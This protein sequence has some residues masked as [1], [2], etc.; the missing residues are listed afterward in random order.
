M[1]LLSNNLDQSCN[2]T[3]TLNDISHPD[4]SPFAEI[5]EDDYKEIMNIY[6]LQERDQNQNNSKTSNSK[7]DQRLQHLDE[8]FKRNKHL[9]INQ[10]SVYFSKGDSWTF[11]TDTFTSGLSSN[12]Q[13][14]QLVSKLHALGGQYKKL[15]KHTSTQNVAE[16]TSVESSEGYLPHIKE[17]SV[18]NEFSQ[19]VLDQLN[20]NSRISGSKQSVSNG[21]GS[22]ENEIY[23]SESDL[24]SSYQQSNPITQTYNLTTSAPVSKRSYRKQSLKNRLQAPPSNFEDD[25]S[26]YSKKMDQVP[27]KH[28]KSRK[29]SGKSKHSQ[30]RANNSQRI[31]SR[32]TSGRLSKYS[33]RS[34]KSKG[35]QK[36]Q[37]RQYQQPP[38]QP[39]QHE[40]SYYHRH[41]DSEAGENDDGDESMQGS[42]L[43]ESDKYIIQGSGVYIIP[44]NGFD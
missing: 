16:A 40:D 21:Y 19:Q 11:G 15:G 43:K 38:K 44:Q 35:L 1:Q 26:F 24:A 6:K 33:N 18:N 41:P 17:S 23:L 27:T 22:G 39:K 31:K 12:G 29:Y 25:P 5:S 4:D 9:I 28:P 36:H 30:E 3:N 34:N 7:E 14:N 13:G 32:K 20:S 42:L 10:N 2:V 8:S 37:D